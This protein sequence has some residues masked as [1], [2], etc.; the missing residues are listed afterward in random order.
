MSYFEWF[1]AKDG[2]HVA[3]RPWQA[4][5]VAH[6]VPTEVVYPDYTLAWRRYQPME[7][8]Q[9]LY[10]TFVDTDPTAE[11]V[12]D[13]ANQYG[14]LGLWGNVWPED[15]EPSMPVHGEPIA[16]WLAYLADLRDA[17]EV[18]D[19][20]LRRDQAA[21]AGWVSMGVDNDVPYVRPAPDGPLARGRPFVKQRQLA[22]GMLAL[23]LRD[24]HIYVVESLPPGNAWGIA[25]TWLQAQ[26]NWHL[27]EYTTPFLAYDEADD[28]AVPMRMQT[29]PKHLYGALWLQFALSV[30]GTDR[31]LQCRNCGNWFRVPPKARRPNTAHCST[32]CRVQAARRRL[33]EAATTGSC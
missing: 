18:W 24:P 19:V 20:L 23:A 30:R 7:G 25:L 9:V 31:D 8:K 15:T 27:T 13:F 12:Q 26:I 1:V 5:G 17:L 33:A 4:L 14:L 6:P 28:S 16:Q 21:L 22:D 29:M 2:Y 3:V 32:K 11:G 10:R